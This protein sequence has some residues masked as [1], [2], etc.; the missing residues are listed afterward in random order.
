M[1][2]NDLRTLRELAGVGTPTGII[3]L[4]LHRSKIAISSKAAKEHISLDSRG[5]CGPVAYG[6]RRVAISV[7][8]RK[9]KFKPCPVHRLIRTTDSYG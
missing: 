2:E 3:A 9:C 6:T 4:K 1:V 7:Y 5:S 8:A